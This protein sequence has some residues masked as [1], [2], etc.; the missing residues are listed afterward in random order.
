MNVFSVAFCVQVDWCGT[1]GEKFNQRY[2]QQSLVL[3]TF[4][5]FLEPRPMDSD[6]LIAIVSIWQCFHLLCSCQLD[7]LPNAFVVIFAI[8][9]PFAGTLWYGSCSL[10]FGKSLWASHCDLFH[11]FYDA[12]VTQRLRWQTLEGFQRGAFPFTVKRSGCSL[13]DL[14]SFYMGVSKTRGTP[15]WVVYKGKPY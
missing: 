12:V 15:K 6:A 14:L 5:T 1:R 8:H 10:C 9:L 3:H 2:P 7:L 13:R 11:C 4:K